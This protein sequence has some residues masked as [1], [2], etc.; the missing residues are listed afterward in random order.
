[1]WW[2]LE[3]AQYEVP[4][5]SNKNSLF[6]G[7]IWMGGVDETGNLK[8]AAM[9]Y[10]QTGIDFWTGPIN[11]NTGGISNAECNKWDRHFVVKRAEVEES[12]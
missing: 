11:Q 9:T 3:D 8:V 4:A 2:D 1:M 6:A 12:I 5:G 7:S 10:R